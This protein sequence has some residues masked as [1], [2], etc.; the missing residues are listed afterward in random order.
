MFD[1]PVTTVPPP[2]T[3]NKRAAREGWWALTCFLAV[4]AL[5]ITVISNAHGGPHSGLLNIPS[6][7]WADVWD[8]VLAGHFWIA[9]GAL[10]SD[11]GPIL[12]KTDTG[13]GRP[14][15][16]AL[17]L[18]ESRGAKPLLSRPPDHPSD[19]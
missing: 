9:T 17:Y 19:L 6:K 4:A 1:R 15:L 2:I 14:D 3:R 18:A 12:L 7:A 13:E 11:E 5:D 16:A 8:A 10:Y